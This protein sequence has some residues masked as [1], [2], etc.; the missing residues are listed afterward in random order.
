MKEQAKKILSNNIFLK[1]FSL[2]IGIQFVIGYFLQEKNIL[3]DNFKIAIGELAL[4][5]IISLTVYFLLKLIRHLLKKIHL[6]K[7]DNKI[8][9]LDFLHYFTIIIVCWIPVFIAF[10]P[11]IF[12]LQ[13]Y[14]KN[15]HNFSRFIS[16]FFYFPC[17]TCYNKNSEPDAKHL[18]SV[19]GSRKQEKV[20]LAKTKGC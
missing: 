7:F 11:A 13:N 8:L 6:D 5:L 1:I 3:F 16:S 9:K 17:K 10:Y 15:I 12:L 4:I 14:S 19:T 18:A 20:L 2:I